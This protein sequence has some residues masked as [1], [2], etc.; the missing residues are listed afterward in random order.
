MKR[1][2]PSVRPLAALVLPFA[3]LAACSG[4]A[5]GPEAALAPGESLAFEGTWSAEGTRQTLKLESGHQASLLS[6]TGSLLLVGRRALGVGFRAETIGMSDSAT[7][8]TG[9]SVWTDERGDKVYSRLSGQPMGTGSQVTG[10][11]TGGTGR[12]AGLTGA[13]EFRWRYVI[14]TADGVVSGQTTD[15]KGTVTAARAETPRR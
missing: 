14:D 3:V 4:P 8:G 10:V 2:S 5:K 6:L 12:Y 7:G 13:Y 11:I 9:Y 1:L 15:L